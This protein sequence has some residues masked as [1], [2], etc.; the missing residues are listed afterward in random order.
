MDNLKERIRTLEETVRLLTLEND[1]LAERADEARLLGTVAEKISAG[2]DDSLVLSAGLEQISLLRDIPFCLCCRIEADQVVSHSGYFSFTHEPFLRITCPLVPALKALIESGASVLD[3]EQCRVAGLSALMEPIGFDPTSLL[4][5]PYRLQTGEPGFFLFSDNRT[6][7]R[8]LEQRSLLERVSGLITARMDLLLLV[9]ALNESRHELDRK[10]EER[11]RELTSM[12]DEL[13]RQIEKR[14]HFENALDNEKTFSDTIIDSLPGIFYICDDQFRLLRMND[15]EKE[16]TG[17]SLEEMTRK[18]VLDLFPQDRGMMELKMR[19][20]FESGSAVW[21]AAMVTKS[22][23]SISFYLTGFRMVLK[24]QRYAVGVGI[25]ISERKQLEQQLMH[26]QK[27]EAIGALAGGVAHDFNNI[28]SAIIGYASI[29]RMKMPPGNDQR[30]FVEQILASSERAAGLTKSLLAFSRKQAIELKP[31][32]VGDLIAGFQKILARLIGE[33]IEFRISPPRADLMVLAD[34]GQLEQVLM[35]LVTNARDAMPR[36]GTLKVAVEKAVLETDGN[37]LKRGEYALLSVSD[38]G[39][40]M[41]AETLEH[42]FEPF[43][44]TKEA[45]KGTGLG[46]AIAYGIMRKHNG[47]IL[48]QSTPGQGSQFRIYLPLIASLAPAREEIEELLPAGAETV[49]LVED[50]KSVREVARMILEAYGYTVLEAT[51]GHEALNM[52][53][54]DPKRV[55]LLI[56]DLVM[57]GMNGRETYEAIKKLR[58]TISVIFMSGYTADIIAQK[59]IM[60]EG[61]NFLSKPINPSTLLKKIREVL[62]KDHSP[63]EGTSP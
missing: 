14:M 7:P 57:P 3:P 58:P 54:E 6:E 53:R 39:T 44:T 15:N 52:F 41:D 26:S 33:D 11:T 50:E 9:Q 55:D 22:G 12:N 20:V 5:I 21:E 56:C 60:D 10:V 17:Y 23:A 31:V 47:S 48:V 35:N 16:T 37:E 32:N 2:N 24:D 30:H 46:L 8:L 27:M 51:N 4:L 61:I 49:L 18:N 62:M 28:L 34:K 36:G 43:Y 1:Q 25:D 42:I 13:H 19:E 38:T 59:G 40:G 63:G 45:G 29:L